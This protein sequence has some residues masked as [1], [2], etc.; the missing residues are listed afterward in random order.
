MSH[1][2]WV[3]LVQAVSMV[4]I[5]S[6]AWWLQ[7]RMHNG[8]WVDCCWTLG[9]GAVAVLGAL[10]PFPADEPG[11]RWLAAIL[12]ALWSLRLGWHLVE[13]TLKGAEDVRY[14]RFR[15][16]WGE[17]FERRMFWFLQIQA[18]AGLVLAGGVLLAAHRPGPLD[19]RDA[20][21]VLIF[22]AA[23]AGES[24][25]DRQMRAFRQAKREA[26]KAGQKTETICRRGLWGWSRHPNYFFEWLGWWT[27]VPLGLSLASPLSFLVILPPAMMYWLL[28]HVSGIPPLE[29]EMSEKHA[30]DFA[31][32]RDEVSAF[33]PLPPG[34]N[35]RA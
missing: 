14:A 2:I 24:F 6:G 32:Y 30:D 20:L 15:R 25:A 21:G 9:T 28:V 16:E 1:L 23:L 17:D 8:G 34:R 31:R 33:V 29:R 3:F 12:V 18:A 10:L 27:Y 35:G 5:M 13:R 22:V 4:V 19:W 7:R 26:G 11:R